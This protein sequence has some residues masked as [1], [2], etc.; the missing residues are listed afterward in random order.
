[1]ADITAGPLLDNPW[2]RA[3]GLDA[4][5]TTTGAS[6]EATAGAA[7]H[8]NLAGRLFR[9]ADAYE[10]TPSPDGDGGTLPATEP[11]PMLSADDANERYGIKGHLEFDNPVPEP[12]AEDR[13]Q[14]ARA[15]L[16]RQSVLMRAPDT[17]ATGAA[18]V[19]TGIG[20]GLLDPFQDAAMFIPFVGEA[21]AAN[22][23]AAAGPSLAG[24]A[25]VRAGIGA[26][27]GA[28][29]TAA[30]QPLQWGLSQS[31]G[32]DY[33]A[34]DAL[35]NI[36]YGGAGGALLHAG[37]GLTRDLWKGVKPAPGVVS[38]DGGSPPV[39]AD[40]AGLAAG[41]Q[42]AGTS[43]A[44]EPGSPIA[45]AEP[46]GDVADTEAVPPPAD[47]GVYEKHTPLADAAPVDDALPPGYMLR[48]GGLDADSAALIS[49]LQGRLAEDGLSLRARA[50]LERQLDQVTSSLG[51][52][53][54]VAK[55]NLAARSDE[56]GR[57]I[58]ALL[59]DH[60]AAPEEVAR[61]L[62]S[63]AE[64]GRR[65]AA[66]QRVVMDSLPLDAKEAAMR[67][68][69]GELAANGQVDGA[70]KVL[71]DMGPA[72]PRD[73]ASPLLGS[74]LASP[75]ESASAPPGGGAGKDFADLAQR[76]SEAQARHDAAAHELSGLQSE[77]A[78]L[79]EQRS[80]AERD[81]AAA[82]ERRRAAHEVAD[83][84]MP[85]E[86]AMAEEAQ[87]GQVERDNAA[88]IG[89]DSAPTSVTVARRFM[90]EKEDGKWAIIDTAAGDDPDLASRWWGDDIHRERKT[91]REAIADAETL[92]A[93]IGRPDPAFTPD[94]VAV[95]AR[96][97][98]D[99]ARIDA[100]IAAAHAKLADIDAAEE[101][102][103]PRLDDAAGRRVA[104]EYDLL[105]LRETRMP[106]DAEVSAMAARAEVSAP[107]GSE[108]RLADDLQR[109]EQ[110]V[111]ALR[112]GGAIP[113]DDPHLALADAAAAEGEGM[114]KAYEAA[115]GCL[116]T[117]GML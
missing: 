1:M 107:R 74:P 6:V 25:A 42:P 63:Q 53:L 16:A 65:L 88:P 33:G 71:A 12:V 104:A 40:G 106:T 35:L 32:E 3:Q 66:L 117:G 93:R 86:R 105:G 87:P 84:Q 54:D 85:I 80:A 47:G 30:V 45:A 29:G 21:R 36:A 15:S 67:S 101:A 90:V 20:T 57:M 76:V 72:A 73:P 38:A 31:E 13:Y 28:A 60:P 26:V 75:I 10:R 34:V 9:W 23:L 89:R 69:V 113:A 82:M 50:E 91:K 58:R 110:R 100:D 98:G 116:M 14:A 96:L 68:A 27:D 48:L 83:G 44:N 103:A 4:I 52:E 2:L 37:G 97:G 51:S 95:A 111:Q 11:T 102:L 18:K 49:H 115:A 19:A 64:T 55:A 70:A 17:L 112:D 108:G 5:P 77:A 78:G 46:A 8:D 59:A 41:A 39:A 22:W 7:L 61:Q 24:R 109:A 99:R 56:D 81:L 62:A 92:A 94:A 43:L 79:T 114:A